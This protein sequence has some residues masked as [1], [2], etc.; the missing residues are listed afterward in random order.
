M[1][2]RKKHMLSVENEFTFLAKQFNA[3]LFIMCIKLIKQ[4]KK[5]KLSENGKARVGFFFLKII[6]TIYIVTLLLSLIICILIYNTSSACLFSFTPNALVTLVER[7]RNG[8]KRLE[9][10]YNF[11]CICV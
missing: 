8:Q 7:Y 3:L 5:L 4:Q 11:M 1:I 9:K 6:H 2:E 10:L